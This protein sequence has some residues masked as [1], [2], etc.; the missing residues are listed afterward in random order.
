M[1]ETL[2]TDLYAP[3]VWGDMASEE[4][5]GRAIIATS[6]ATVTR[7][8]LVGVPGAVINFPKWGVLNDLD[9]I[10]EGNAMGLEKMSQTNS[11]AT[12]KAAGKAVEISDTASL[13]GI[14]NPQDEA[15]RQFGVL[16]ARKVDEDL[17]TAATSVVTDGIDHK[18]GTATDS[19]PLQATITGGFTWNNLV[20]ALNAFGDDFEPSEFAGLV[21]RS[22]QRAEI[23]KDPLFIQASQTNAGGPGSLVNRGLIGDIAGVPVYVTNRLAQGHAL[24]LKQNSLGLFYKRRPIV[25]RDRDIIRQSTV[26]ATNLHYAVKRLND[27]GVLDITIE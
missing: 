6:T 12:I 9:D 4:F 24:L 23:M 19:K 20:D 16:A 3:E 22:E 15:I 21:I 26:I 18:G 1:A 17:I 10:T 2:S 8:D 25:E 11:Q 7:D 14:G 27:K 5:K 13:V